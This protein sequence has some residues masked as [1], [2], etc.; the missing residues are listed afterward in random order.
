[1][2]TI[3]HEHL[4]PSGVDILSF[5]AMEAVNVQDEPRAKRRGKESEVVFLPVCVQQ[6]SKYISIE[7]LPT[8]AA[9]TRGQEAGPNLTRHKSC[10]ADTKKHW[11]NESNI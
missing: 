4:F 2:K 9:T 6:V 7:W 11:E 5:G 8:D 1:M 10:I 3:Q